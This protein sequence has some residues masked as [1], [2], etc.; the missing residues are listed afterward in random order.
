[1]GSMEVLY[2]SA[3]LCRYFLRVKTVSSRYVSFIPRAIL[4]DCNFFHN[5]NRFEKKSVLFQ[6]TFELI[7]CHQPLTKLHIMGNTKGAAPRSAIT[8]GAY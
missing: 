2:L 8:Q 5:V 3:S 6:G 1:M 7:V 4:T